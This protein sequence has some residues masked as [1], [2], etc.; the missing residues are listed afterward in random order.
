MLISVQAPTGDGAGACYIGTKLIRVRW[1]L[2]ELAIY[3]E[4]TVASGQR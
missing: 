3:L 1:N 2:V 4:A